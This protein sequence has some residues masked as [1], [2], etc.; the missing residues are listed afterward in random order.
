[1]LQ[2]GIYPT[3]HGNSK[4]STVRHDTYFTNVY[5]GN[6]FILASNTYI[7]LHRQRDVA[8]DPLRRRL[9]ALNSWESARVGRSRIA[10]IAIINLKSTFVYQRLTSNRRS[11]RTSCRD[12]FKFRHC[13]SY[14]SFTIL[15][16]IISSGTSQHSGVG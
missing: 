14:S 16:S 6:L 8:K 1:M 4:K 2:Q 11:R 9:S 15:P 13:L 5:R 12:C 7:S 10:P 3:T